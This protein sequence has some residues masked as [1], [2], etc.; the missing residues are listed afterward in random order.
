MDA[1]FL[2]DALTLL[3]VLNPIGGS[4]W[5]L[6]LTRG[7]P[8]R[9]RLGVA[10][11]A[12]LFAAIILI[13]FIAIGEVVLD[14]IGVRLPS[15][16]VAGGLVLLLVG[17]RM[18]LGG[19]APGAAAGGP[20]ETRDVAIFPLATPL[21]A[22]PGA[23]IAAV[24]L[25]ENDRFSLAEQFATSLVVVGILFATFLAMAVS[26]FI[27]KAIPAAGAS[28]LSRVLGLILSSLAMQTMLDG[29]RPYL[30]SIATAGGAR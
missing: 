10:W 17:L 8:K 20:G 27:E 11:R 30:A 12:C 9:E 28:V 25:T 7:M 14:G 4:M 19:E 23:I 15:F 29:L 1:K 13:V 22:G 18:V 16:R 5:F 3:V 21:L 26:H 6:T 2:Q 24:L